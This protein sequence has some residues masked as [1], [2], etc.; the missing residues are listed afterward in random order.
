LAEEPI[1]N[2][3]WKYPVTIKTTDGTVYYTDDIEIIGPFVKFVAYAYIMAR[4]RG[5]YM[6]PPTLIL[7]DR[8]I[9]E[10]TIGKTDTL[11][12]ALLPREDGNDNH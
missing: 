11:Q 8:S 2:L 6:D 12:K 7:P 4:D 5:S 1:E 10:V 3:R 9:T